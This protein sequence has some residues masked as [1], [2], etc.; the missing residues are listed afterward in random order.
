MP[1][2]EASDRRTA[3]V[4]WERAMTT[5]GLWEAEFHRPL[6]GDEL[7]GGA[8]TTRPRVCENALIA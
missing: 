4:G 8:D 6:S 3:A 1:A 2:N 7:K 5:G